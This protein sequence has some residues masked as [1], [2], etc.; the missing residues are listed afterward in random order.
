MAFMMKGRLKITGAGFESFTAGPD[1]M[2]LMPSHTDHR[3]EV[4]E[5]CVYVR[6]YIIGDNLD[7][8]NRIV[9]EKQLQREACQGGGLF[10]LP[11]LP[12]VRNL[13]EQ[14]AAY[15]R[16]RLLCCDIHTLKQRELSAIIQAYYKPAV[17]RRFLVPLYRSNCSFTNKV[18]ALSNGYLN[19]EQMAERLNM[20][21]S[22]F[23]RNFTEQFKES[24]G[25]WL[26]RVRTKALYR[27]LRFSDRSLDEIAVKLKFSS[28]QNMSNFCH[29]KLGGTPMQVRAGDVKEP[30]E[31][32][33]AVANR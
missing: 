20:S 26:T 19:I 11:M 32:L 29:K 22:T 2:F 23:I 16:D 6:L 24:P 28:P 15:A 21:R 13:I 12:V 33:E 1:E 30:P 8:C 31:I 5:H 25:R 27:E 4:L 17:L 10:T 3:I 14:I 7:F 9:S 18:I